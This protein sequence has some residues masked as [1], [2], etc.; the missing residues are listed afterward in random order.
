MSL[1]WREIDKILDEIPLEGSFIREIRQPNHPQLI[2]ELYRPGHSFRLLFSFSNPHCRLHLLTRRLD[3]PHQPPRFVAFLRAHIRGGKIVAA[4]QIERERI[5]K[6]E[7]SKGGKTVFL[8]AR[9][10]AAAANMIVTDPAGTILDALY[11]RPKRGEISGQHYSVQ[12]DLRPT[13]GAASSEKKEFSV[14]ELPGPGSFNERVEQHYF[15]LEEQQEATKIRRSLMS[16]LAR[17]ENRVLA[18]N[19][20][21]QKK[22]ENNRDFHTFKRWGDLILSNLHNV[23]KGERWLTVADDLSPGSTLAIELDPQITPA[24]NAEAYYK[25]FRKAKTGL[26]NLEEEQRQQNQELE[27][28]RKKI[29]RFETEENLERLREEARKERRRKPGKTGEIAPGLAFVSGPFRI[30]VGRNAREND[31]LLR[32]FVR[33]NDT[34]LHAR[35]Y[36]GAYVFIRSIPGK[37]IPLQTLLDAATLALFY[38]KGRQ[39]A[40]GDVFY[41]QV[42]YLKRVKDGKTGLVIPSQEK[43]LRVRLES[44]RLARLQNP[45]SEDQ[46]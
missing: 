28:I 17:R 14:R 40:Q 6:I 13:A 7:V 24:Q 18:A 20:A 2:L 25:R 37:S 4:E 32:V 11:R 9:L 29:A 45:D 3:N 30:L 42:K 10:W 23:N 46:S 31:A 43:N 39:S 38:S 21:L 44:R 27:R 16:Q 19:A 36:A 8:W 15:R 35:D 33:G 41:T 12:D 1:N 5:V 26:K 34:W 22:V